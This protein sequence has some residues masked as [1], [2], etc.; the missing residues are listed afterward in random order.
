MMWRYRF[1][2]FF[3]IVLF[4]LI[5]MRLFYWQVVR[6]EELVDMAKAQYGK[7]ALIM[8]QRGEIKTSDGFPLATNKYTYLVF[9]N[10]KEVKGEDKEKVSL[11]LA[12]K[13]GIDTASVSA[14]L[15]KD[16]Y[17]VPIKSGIDIAAKEELEKL[18]LRG[19]GFE[20]QTVRFYPEASMAAQ[21]IGFV[22]KNDAGE[23]TGYFGL[24]GYYDRQLKGKAAIATQIHDAFGRPIVARTDSAAPLNGRSVTLSIDRALQFV[25]ETKL[26]KGVEKYQAAGGMAAVINPKTGELLAIA[27]VPSFDQRTFYE[28]DPS[29]YKNPFISYLYEPGST[30]KALVMAA[31]IDAGVV[32]SD[33]KCPICE[34]P[35]QIGEYQIKTWNNEYRKDITMT[36]V[37]QH[38]DNTGMVYVSKQ[39]GL[40]KMLFYFKKFGIGELT[41]IDLQGEVFPELRPAD[42]W[43]EIDVATAS[44]GQGISVTAMELLSGFAALANDGV[45]MQP[46]IVTKIETPEGEIIDVKPKE[47]NR[48]V[49]EKTAKVMTEILVN[50]VEKG[51]A[52]F[53]KPK[54]YRVAGK[55]GT[56]Q[57]PIA[58]KYDPTKTIAS[59]IGFAPAD[60]PKFAMLVV[61]DRPTTSI[62]GAETAAPVFFDIAKD[63]FTYY[64]IPP[65]E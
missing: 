58:G 16:L 65:T 38:S 57:I 17:W 6:A 1:T 24:E 27:S 5:S 32:K 18:K 48:P 7:T 55:T 50:A 35:L 3:F 43:Y 60:D 39:L 34:K 44:F 37:I 12:A 11:L 45:R 36:E 22:G 20:Q 64:N 13:L 52:K 33:T 61:I 56:A 49:S 9:M 19:I 21:L 23:D 25:T 31:G 62:Y 42:K 28:Y 40:E 59:F 29:L 46:H 53:A 10:P 41:G 4:F 54:G 47:I 63:I 8:P 15:S 14:A 51:E 30:F 26:K 2:L